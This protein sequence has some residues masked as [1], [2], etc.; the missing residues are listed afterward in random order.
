VNRVGVDGKG[1]EYSGASAV[2]DFL[3][4]PLSEDSN[5]ELVTTTTLSGAELLAYRERFPAW[6]DADA[7]TLS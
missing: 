6:M 5:Q 4:T 3:G 1:H 2:L 7:F